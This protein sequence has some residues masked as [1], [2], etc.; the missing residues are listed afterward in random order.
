LTKYSP[1]PVNPKFSHKSAIL[2]YGVV[3]FEAC[4]DENHGCTY[5]HTYIHALRGLFDSGANLKKNENS[6]PLESSF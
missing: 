1:P 6:W 2:Y 4:D 5:I 3:F